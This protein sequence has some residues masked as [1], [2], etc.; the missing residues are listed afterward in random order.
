MVDTSLY[1]GALRTCQRLLHRPRTIVSDTSDRSF[2]ETTVENALLAEF[3]EGA[4]LAPHIDSDAR[5][6]RSED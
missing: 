5:Y 3:A 4:A 2:T 6:I 1:A